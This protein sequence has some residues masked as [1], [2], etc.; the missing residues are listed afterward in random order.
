[1]APAFRRRVTATLAAHYGIAA[2]TLDAPGTTLLPIDPAR[3]DDWLE[4]M[5]VGTRIGLEVPPPLREQV[6]AVVAAH[7]ADHLLRAADFVAA[8]G[9][10]GARVGHMKVYMLDASAFRPF[11]PDARFTVR[12]LTETDRAAFDEFLAR[13]PADDRVEADIGLDQGSPFGVF[14][15]ARLVAGASTYL[16]LGMVDVGV[17]TDPA[18]RRLGLGKAVV[19]AVGEHVRAQGG[20]LCYR[21]A[22]SNTGSQG[23]AEGLRLSLYGTIEAVHPRLKA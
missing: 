8:W 3:W 23:V 14:D 13:C 19:S 9:Q 6:E 10:E 18:Y 2:D 17:L 5:P 7:P 22:L 1:M 20:I 4:L 15:G 11:T 21:H 16:W 12:A